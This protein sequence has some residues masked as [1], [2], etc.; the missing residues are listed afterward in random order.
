MSAKMASRRPETVCL[1]AN[2]LPQR[3]LEKSQG[4]T[5]HKWT[6]LVSASPH[7]TQTHRLSRARARTHHS[8]TTCTQHHYVQ[9][10]RCTPQSGED[11]KRR[12]DAWEEPMAEPPDARLAEDFLIRPGRHSSSEAALAHADGRT[13]ASMCSRL[14]IPTSGLP[15]LARCTPQ[16]LLASTA[17]RGPATPWAPAHP[18]ASAAPY[19]DATARTSMT[20]KQ[21][22]FCLKVFAHIWLL[23]S[24]LPRSLNMSWPVCPCFSGRVQSGLAE[25][26]PRRGQF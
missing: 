9:L 24:L 25:V 5:P 16:W 18:L 6:E 4:L 21:N 23:L 12:Q 1:E 10:R 17:P 14:T 8:R 15:P 26:K 22:R 19:P 2:R 13:C 20:R 3:S 7:R 11:S